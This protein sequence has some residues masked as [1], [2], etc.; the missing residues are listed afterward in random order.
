LRSEGAL[1]L[2]LVMC[3]VAYSLIDD[4]SDKLRS[5]VGAVIKHRNAMRGL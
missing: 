1:L 3:P 5:T 2:T 4:A